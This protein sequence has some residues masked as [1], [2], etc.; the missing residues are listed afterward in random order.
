MEY[1]V[2]ILIVPFMIAP[3]I[4]TKKYSINKNG[5]P[6]HDKVDVA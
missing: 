3:L 5:L 4:K 2:S 1:R 6:T